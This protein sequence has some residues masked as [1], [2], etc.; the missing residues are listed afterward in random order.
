MTR[1][2]PGLVQ[3]RVARQTGR[4]V[5]VWA[6]DALG[7]E[8][9]AGDWVTVCVEHGTDCHHETRRLAV[10][11]AAEPR[12]W[13]EACQEIDGPADPGLTPGGPVV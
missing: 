13:C 1:A 4:V 2:E 12:T 5:E 11:W 3:R 9:E 10:G 6:A 7:V 8:D